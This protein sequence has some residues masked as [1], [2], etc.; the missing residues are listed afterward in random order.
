MQ[1]ST[2]SPCTD[3]KDLKYIDAYIQAWDWNR[4]YIAFSTEWTIVGIVYVYLCLHLN[5]SCQKGNQA[6][7]PGECIHVH[8]T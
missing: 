4:V 6:W 5:I 1:I 3:G 2:T 8:I 7:K